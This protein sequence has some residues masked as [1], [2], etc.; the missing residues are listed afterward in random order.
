MQ[1]PFLDLKAQHEIV[2]SE[3]LSLWQEIMDTAGFIG[4]QHVSGFE[5]EF[6][7]AVQ[8][9]H[10]VAVS[11]GT[12][13]LLFL[14]EALGLERGEEVIVPVNTF[15][16]T[17]E[18]VS[19]AGG[20]V[21]FVDV[22]PD[23]CNMDWTQIEA[24]ITPKTRGIVPVHLYGQPADMDPIRAIAAA[25]GLWVVEDAAQAHLAEYKGQPTGTLG[26]AAG[27]S[28]YPG[29]NLG[30]CGDAG[31]VVTNDAYLAE[32]VRMLRDHGS[33]KKYYHDFEGYNGRCDALQAAALRVKLR[34]L[35]SWNES[36]RRIAQAY[37]DRLADIDGIKLPVVAPGCLPV[38]HL[39]VIQVAKRDEVQAYLA[40][41]G[42]ATALHYPVPLHLQKAYARLGYRKG[43]FPVAEEC[44]E[45]LLS[46]PMFPQL[47]DDDVARVCD[48]LCAAVHARKE[49]VA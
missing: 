31:A 35:P 33:S 46:L 48:S 6:A 8:A 17:S 28:F 13:A 30:A 7:A 3:I 21:V 37:L 14:F 4:G 42:I 22:R 32:R 9:E 16:A 40:E 34:Y 15:I 44:A 27:F 18:A 5:A 2:K 36:R 45:H 20:N 39:F 11:N 26:L 12:D 47:A 1:I 23:T 41:H 24:A 25:H 10:C 19:K 43:S 29:K 49:R 38:W